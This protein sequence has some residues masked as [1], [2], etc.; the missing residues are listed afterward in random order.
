VRKRLCGVDRSIYYGRQLKEIWRIA[1]VLA[2]EY[3]LGEPIDVILDALLAY[4][5]TLKD[6][7][8]AGIDTSKIPGHR[9]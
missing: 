9:D 8:E 4:A 5:K 6:M 1:R 7:K 3:R 2:K